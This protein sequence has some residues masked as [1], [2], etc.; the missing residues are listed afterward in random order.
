MT[1]IIL[2]FFG[3]KIPVFPFYVWLPEAHVES[4]TEMSILLAS[5]I[6]KFGVFGLLRIGY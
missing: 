1:V 5:I 2:V 4:N 3:V 6:L